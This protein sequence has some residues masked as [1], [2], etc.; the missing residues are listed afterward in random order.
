MFKGFRPRADLHQ[1]TSIPN[2][3]FDEIMAKVDTVAELK[4]LLAIFRKTYGWVDSIGAD[5]TPVY[6]LEDAISYSQFKELT[7]LTDTSIAN[8][9]KRAIEHGF[10]VCVK[11]G[12]LNDGCS[13]YRLR[14]RGEEVITSEPLMETEPHKSEAEEKMIVVTEEQRISTKKEALAEL[15]PPTQPLDPPTKPGRKKPLSFREKPLEDWNCNDLLSYFRDKYRN[16]LGIGY[17]LVSAKDR[18]QAKMLLESGE[19]K[20]ED[21]IKTID[22]YLQ[23]YRDIPGLPEGFPS[24]SVF[25]G[26]RNLIFPAALVGT[27]AAKGKPNM[28]IREYREPVEKLIVPNSWDWEG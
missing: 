10:V 23:N 28:D 6:K 11:T 21:I 22:F 2:E 27:W 5:G 12:G 4:I 3:F 8:G 7:G 25:F 13:V 15:R 18:K 17:P 16:F 19:I 9:L 26:W 14:Q 24:W 20:R 1:F